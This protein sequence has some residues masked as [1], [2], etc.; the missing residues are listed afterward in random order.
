LKAGDPVT[1]TVTVT[2]AGTVAGD[3]VVEAYVKTPQGEGPRHSLVAFERVK[4]TPGASRQVTLKIDPRSLSSVDD[5]GNRS[6]LEGK[7][8]LTVGGAQPDETQAKSEA[9]FTVNGTA[10][11]PK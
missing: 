5:Q 9:V 1:A 10:A 6:I 7:Y 2:N 8:A 11:L 4:L 3:E